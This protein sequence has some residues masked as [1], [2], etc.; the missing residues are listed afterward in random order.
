[1]D[2]LA[3]FNAVD[4]VQDIVQLRAMVRDAAALARQAMTER[5]QW[6]NRYKIETH[7]LVQI[8]EV[9]L[10]ELVHMAMNKP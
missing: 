7:D 6:K 1:M 8:R 9:T 4:D 10:D 5:D 3:K 2:P